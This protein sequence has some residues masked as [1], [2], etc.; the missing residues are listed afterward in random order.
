[1]NQIA[2]P[3]S[4]PVIDWLDFVDA[5]T[6]WGIIDKNLTSTDVD[7]IFIATN[8]EDEDLE[9]NDDSSLCRFEFVE[10]IARMAKT[11]YYEKGLCKTVHEACSALLEKYVLPNTIE[12][13]EWQEFRD[14]ELWTLEVDDLLKA[15]L[16]GME[17]LYRKFAAGGK[18]KIKAFQKDDALS[19]LAAAATQAQIAGD[20]GSLAPTNA[21]AS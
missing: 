16:A 19:L 14:T 1:M 11:K 17:A 4:Y 18:A 6:A 7:R 10:I 2:N 9:E 3:K 12:Q 15:N 21:P 5:C 13:M 8:F 20:L